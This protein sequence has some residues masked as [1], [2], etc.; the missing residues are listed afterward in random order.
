M[1][2]LNDWRNQMGKFL[3][4]HPNVPEVIEKAG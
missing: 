4:C 3:A 1:L 2:P